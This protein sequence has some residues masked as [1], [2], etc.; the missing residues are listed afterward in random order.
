[1]LFPGFILF[2]FTLLLYAPKHWFRILYLMVSRRL[3]LDWINLANRPSC[4]IKNYKTYCNR[5]FFIIVVDIAILC[6]SRAAAA[7][8]T[9]AARDLSAT[10]KYFFLQHSPE[11]RNSSAAIEN[12]L[13]W[14]TL[15]FKANA[16][17]EDTR[18]MVPWTFLERETWLADIHTLVQLQWNGGWFPTSDLEDLFIFPM[19]ESLE[20]L[21]SRDTYQ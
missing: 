15:H 6:G 20:S 10:V 8:C 2:C 12:A 4:K 3:Q 7:H 14:N 18:T 16:K 5:E 19:Q 13:Y 1:M 21:D 9:S 11:Q 17:N